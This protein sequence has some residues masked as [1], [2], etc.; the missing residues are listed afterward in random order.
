[1]SR[2]PRDVSTLGSP[3]CFAIGVFS[4]C[5]EPADEEDRRPL[6]GERTPLRFCSRFGSGCVCMRRGC[7]LL[8]VEGDILLDVGVMLLEVGVLLLDVGVVLVAC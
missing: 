6:T 8:A 5:F 1:M 3:R 7:L 2:S 4:D